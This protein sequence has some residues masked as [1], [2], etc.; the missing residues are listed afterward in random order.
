PV[1]LMMCFPGCGLL[2]TVNGTVNAPDASAVADPACAESKSK[3]T[4]SPLAKPDPEAERWVPG[5]PEDR[6]RT[7]AGPAAPAETPTE[8]TMTIDAIMTMRFRLFIA[9]TTP[10]SART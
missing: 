9:T 4:T 1:A 3:S 7:S 2:G 10:L 6:L 5:G 8:T